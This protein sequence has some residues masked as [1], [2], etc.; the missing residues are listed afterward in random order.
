[1]LA[2]LRRDLAFLLGTQR[3]VCLVNCLDQALETRRFVNR[4]GAV[5]PLAEQ[6]QIML[7]QEP[8][9]YDTL[10]GQRVRLR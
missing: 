3:P 5:E 1:M 6:A 2:T 8:D 9:G 7:S 4:P 10:L